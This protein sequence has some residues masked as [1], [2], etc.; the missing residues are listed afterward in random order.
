[1]KIV[2]SRY[3]RH[4]RVLPFSQAIE[5]VT[6]GHPK[7]KQSAYLSTGRIAVVDQ[8]QAR[9]AG[10]INDDGLL[11][12]AKLPC[13]L[14][15]DHTRIFKWIDHPFA[16]GADGVK[17]LQPIAE[18]LPRFAYHFL[19]TLPLPM[20]AGYSRHFK[21]LKSSKVPLPPIAEQRR[22]ADILDEADALR[23]KRAEAIRLANN[24]VPS[25]FNEM[26]GNTITNPKKWREDR[27]GNIADVQGGLQLSAARNAHPIQIPYL[28]VANVHRDRLWLD[29]VKSIGLTENELT[30]TRLIKDDI[31]VVEGHGNPDEI[32]RTAIWDCSIDPCVHQNHLIRVRADRTQVLPTYMNIFLN[33]PAGRQ[34]LTGFGKT[35]SGLNTINV[36]NVRNTRVLIPDLAVQQRF[37][38]VL[39]DLREVGNQQKYSA[40]ELDTLFNALLQRAFRGEL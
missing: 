36:S 32:G 13:V 6:G 1:M 27:V 19:S 7:V 33:S 24:L 25:V 20:N 16:L 4:W 23:R 12:K 17:V 35:T 34:Q 26:F 2:D 31:L 38:V 22:I 30:R 29:E 37:A 10:Y 15:G 8:G 5:D 28:R 21:F 3:P 39:E 14:F 18:L 9:I 11:C 40:T